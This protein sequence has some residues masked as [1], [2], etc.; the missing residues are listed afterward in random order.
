MTTRPC[1]FTHAPP[2]QVTVTPARPS[3]RFSQRTV[4]AARGLLPMLYRRAELCQ[5]LGVTGGDLHEWMRHGLPFQRDARGHLWFDGRAL[6]EWIE[7]TRLSRPRHKLKP[8]E[9]YCFRCQRA[10][11]LID[12][13]ERR[14]GRH[15]LRSGK[16]PH[17]QGTISRGGFH[18]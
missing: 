12:P 13:T 14:N 6:A 10:V 2:F 15:V 11:P 16:C 4:V 5:K 7:T 9:A 3:K 18:D 1:A 8:D 17:C